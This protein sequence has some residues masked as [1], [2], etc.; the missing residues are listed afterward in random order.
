MLRKT[1]KL[2]DHGKI[3]WALV[4][5]YC[6]VMCTASLHDAVS[7]L[8]AFKKSVTPCLCND[9]FFYDQTTWFIV[10][11]GTIIFCETTGFI[12]S[13]KF[14]VNIHIRE[15]TSQKQIS[16]WFIGGNVI[17]VVLVFLF[18]LSYLHSSLRYSSLFTLSYKPSFSFLL[19]LFSL[20]FQRGSTCFILYLRKLFPF[21]Y[22]CSMF[23]LYYIFKTRR[24]EYSDTNRKT[25]TFFVVEF[26][27]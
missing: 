2:Y 5:K 16:V 20:Y 10:K 12:W 27:Y 13:K 25:M 18:Y 6:I 9:K 21:C 3:Y 15:N 8:E 17:G 7:I 11:N 1:V 4:V 19:S 14:V 22:V 24:K 23:L 26:V